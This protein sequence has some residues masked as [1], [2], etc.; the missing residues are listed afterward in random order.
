MKALVALALAA[1]V[2]PLSPSLAD[3]TPGELSAAQ[4]AEA[5]GAQM[6]AYDQAAWHATDRFMADLQSAGLTVEQ[7]SH[8][9][10]RGY[11]VEPGKEGQLSAIFYAEVDGT[12]S[13]FARYSVRGSEVTGGGILGED[14]DKSVSDL[15]NRL[16]S[17]RQSAM[18]AMEASDYGICSQTM[19]NTLVLPPISE[20]PISAYILTSTQT[21]GVYPAGG[22]YR[23]DFD[24]AGNLIGQRRFMNSCFPIDWRGERGREAVAMVLSHLLDP[25]PTEI[26]AF[27]SRN[28]PINL[29]IVTVENQR[30]WEIANG[31]IRYAGD[32]PNR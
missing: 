23:F 2:L 16:I 15:A 32:A 1:A 20:G 19:P 12:R 26:H 4:K 25:R 13:A 9:G 28:I 27:V 18:E 3:P 5:R 31:A 6:Y 21:D 30:V 29:M 11:I 8:R 14:A 7:V 24:N 22:H 17:A 10:V